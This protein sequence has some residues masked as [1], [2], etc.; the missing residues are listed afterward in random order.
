MKPVIK[1][2]C[3]PYDSEL[4]QA[5]LKSVKPELWREHFAVEHYEGRW[6][7]IPLVGPLDERFLQE[8]NTRS[9]N[10]DIL[11][12]LPYI[13]QI[14]DA[15]P[16]EKRLVRLL[17]LAPGAVIQE[18]RDKER[19]WACGIVRLHIPIVTSDQVFF[20]VNRRRVV[21]KPGELW[22]FDLQYLHSVRNEGSVARV[23]LVL[24]LVLN[25]ELRRLFPRESTYGHIASL[26]SKLRM[27][28][29]RRRRAR[30]Q[31]GN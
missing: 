26:F 4:L 13:K 15:L 10:N 31:A 6:D 23:H 3:F 5:E 29:R 19:N 11:E 8:G 27:R 9:T 12:N 24:D 1:F 17:R 18:H 2:E 30:R 14:I 28:L 7:S 20:F 16:G 22:Y 21:M 25:D